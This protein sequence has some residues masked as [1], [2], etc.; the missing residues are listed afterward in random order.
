MTLQPRA[1]GETTII[2]NAEDQLDDEDD[3]ISV[4]SVRLQARH[5][6]QE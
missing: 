1:L 3:R 6:L 2:G 4:H 5:P